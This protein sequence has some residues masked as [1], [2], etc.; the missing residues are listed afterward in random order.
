[1]NFANYVRPDSPFYHEHWLGKDTTNSTNV[2]EAFLKFDLDPVADG[3]R[4]GDPGGL[5]L[6]SVLQRANGDEHLAESVNDAARHHLRPPP[7]PSVS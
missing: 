1:M 2:N 4:L 7:L 5:S 6:S 3:G